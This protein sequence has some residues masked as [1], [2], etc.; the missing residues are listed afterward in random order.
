MGIPHLIR[1]NLILTIMKSFKFKRRNGPRVT[2]HPKNVFLFNDNDS[3]YNLSVDIVPDSLDPNPYVKGKRKSK[4][5]A[6][7]K[8][9]HGSKHV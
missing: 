5:F 9:K 1:R 6:L 7:G 4:L 8:S 3:N 2:P